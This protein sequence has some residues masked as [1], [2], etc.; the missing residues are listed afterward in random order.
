MHFAERLSSLDASFL[1]VE[2][3]GTP[4]HVA[5]VLI[6]DAGPLLR[7]DGGLDIDRIRRFIASKLYEIPRCRQKLAYVPIERRPVWVDD[8]SFNLHYH[9]RHTALP[10]PADERLLKR[11]AGRIMSQQLDRWKPLWEMWVV[12][13][14]EGDR[15]AMIIKAHHCMVDGVAATDM[16]SALLTAIPDAP[17]EEPPRW[18]ARP[19]PSPARLLAGE[20]ARRACAPLALVGR[21]VGALRSP[22]QAAASVRDAA[23]AIGG[24]IET[25]FRLAPATPLNPDRIGPHRR[26]D[27]IRLDLGTSRK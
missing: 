14:L 17:I 21:T 2:D 8:E 13:G 11:L 4:M 12:E 26:F 7:P 23:L 3:G 22:L 9:V 1:G 5:A 27:W 20:M 24:T 19:R 6:F 10:P 16:L 18:F 25:S 15:F